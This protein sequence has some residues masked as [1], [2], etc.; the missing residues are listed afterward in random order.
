MHA[1]RQI[2]ECGVDV[3]EEIEAVAGEEPEPVL[4]VRGFGPGIAVEVNGVLPEDDGGF[5][6]VDDDDRIATALET[7]CEYTKPQEIDVEAHINK[8]MEVLF[9]TNPAFKQ[10]FETMTQSDQ[11]KIDDPIGN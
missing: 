11:G 8:A 7:L 10:A 3:L 1:V 6:G 9:K 4:G 2:L 5:I